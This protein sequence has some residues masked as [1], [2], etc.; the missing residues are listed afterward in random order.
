LI[1]GV[2]LAEE[3]SLSWT[4]TVMMVQAC[5]SIS[6]CSVTKSYGSDW[7]RK[8]IILLLAIAGAATG[9]TQVALTMIGI[10]LAC[11]VLLANL[12]ARAWHFHQWHPMTY[13][14]PFASLAAYMTAVATGFAVPYLGHRTASVGG[15]AAIESILRL[16]CAL[17]L[18]YVVTDFD[19]V[20]KFLIVG[21]GVSS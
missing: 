7:I 16:G 3:M 8:V 17:A 15:K 2:V 1:L 4:N 11:I 19:E 14:G 5:P 20:R 21:K 13:H 10:L 9:K 6:A 12:G 18:A